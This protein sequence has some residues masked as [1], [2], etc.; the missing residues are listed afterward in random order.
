M[1]FVI[2]SHAQ[3]QSDFITW[4]QIALVS[5]RCCNTLLRWRQPLK[6]CIS[7]VVGVFYIWEHSPVFKPW[8][9]WSTICRQ[10]FFNFLIV[11]IRSLQKC[12]LLWEPNKYF[13]A[14]LGLKSI[15]SMCAKTIEVGLDC[16]IVMDCFHFGVSRI[17]EPKTTCQVVFEESW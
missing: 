8:L 12:F 2:H 13:V 4:Y 14:I 16:W 6:S 10:H 3:F 11:Q 7:F 15:I 1:W 5:M 17:K 9:W